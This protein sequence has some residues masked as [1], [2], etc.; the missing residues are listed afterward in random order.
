MQSCHQDAN[1]LKSAAKF[2]E[3][4][5]KHQRFN[6][7]TLQQFELLSSHERSEII[8]WLEIHLANIPI[9]EKTKKTGLNK[10]KEGEIKT[11]A[12]L[13]I[14]RYALHEIKQINFI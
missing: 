3:H 2:E 5:T 1:E 13:L 11:N 10:L 9:L 4:L 6:E 12:A 14:L 8:D 7:E